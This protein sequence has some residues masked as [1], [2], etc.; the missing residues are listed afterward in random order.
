MPSDSDLRAKRAQHSDDF[1]FS[2]GKYDFSQVAHLTPP[3]EDQPW[4]VDDPTP[5]WVDADTYRADVGA[6]LAI[7]R[8]AV[9]A[10]NEF[11]QTKGPVALELLNELAAAHLQ[12]LGY[13]PA[14]QPFFR[15][16]DAIWRDAEKNYEDFDSYEIAGYFGWLFGMDTDT[17]HSAYDAVDPPVDHPQ[18][19]GQHA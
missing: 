9:K 14:K 19:E 11:R 6:K 12:L 3:Y 18:N 1:P 2:W 7:H 4:G 16:L 5:A 17:F 10:D 15:W 8:G 13:K